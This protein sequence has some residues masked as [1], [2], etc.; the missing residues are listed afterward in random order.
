[1]NKS[2]IEN[3]D[4][5]RM[6]TVI[7]KMCVG[8]FVLGMSLSVSTVF[9]QESHTDAL[10][11]YYIDTAREAFHKSD[12]RSEENPFTI[13]VLVRRFSLESDGDT[14]Q[15]DTAI[16]RA[17]FTP[18][19]EV[20]ADT[21]AHDS[22]KILRSSF[23][24]DKPSLPALVAK[25][26]W[27]GDFKYS[28]FPNDPGKGDIAISYDSQSS[29]GGLSRF[30]ASGV[31]TLDRASGVLSYEALVVRDDDNATRYSRETFYT[32][33]DG[34][35]LPE[36]IIEHISVIGVW[37]NQYEIRETVLLKLRL[38]VAASQ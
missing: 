22:V 4:F 18:D 9:A 36:K 29:D 7:W 23:L 10:V 32:T 17:Y 37:G 28:L 26:T 5:L 25:S 21:L 34:Y 2:Q 16:V 35:L 12:I 19:A 27:D 13:T 1:M 30:G 20:L 8:L 38:A 14:L 15:I 3:T 11:R 6:R 24:E 33:V 31:I